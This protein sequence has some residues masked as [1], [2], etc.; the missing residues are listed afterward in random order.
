LDQTAPSYAKT[1]DVDAL[2]VWRGDRCLIQGL[3][4][5]LGACEAALVTGPNGAGK[6]TLLRILAGLS[7][8]VSGRVTWGE[9]AMHALPFEGRGEIAY[10]GHLEGLKKDLS[11]AENLALYCALWGRVS[12]VDG[13]LA[14]V[15]LTGLGPRRFRSLSAGQKRRVGL[16]ALRAQR[17]RLWILDEPMTNLDAAGRTLVVEWVRAHLAEGGSAVIAT[18][19][20]D[21]FAGA[22]TLAVEL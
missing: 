5:R 18:H 3:S 13:L 14:A 19:Q 10:R 8:A 15:G 21:E 4:F 9:R 20:P 16:A 17:A 11:I 1:L 12:D 22:A 7:P 6:T 2:D